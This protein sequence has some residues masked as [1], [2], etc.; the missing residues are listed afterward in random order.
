MFS[1]IKAATLAMIAFA[2]GKAL[3]E[4]HTITFNNKWAP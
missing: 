1:S 2:A 4:T 3:A